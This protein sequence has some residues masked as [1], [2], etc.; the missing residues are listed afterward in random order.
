MI[1]LIVSDLDGTLVP[2]NTTDISEEFIETVKELTKKGILFA[3]ASGRQYYNLKNLF[4]EVQ[5]DIAYVCENGA[6]TVYQNEIIDRVELPQET[7]NQIIRR[8]EKE[9][10][11][12]ILVSG[13][14]T[15]YICPKEKSYEDYIRN[16]KNKYK[17]VEDL[18]AIEEPVIKLAMFEKEGTECRNRQDYWQSQFQA[19]IKVVTS[20][21]LWLDFIF[22]NANKGVGVRALAGH[23][24]IKQEEILAFGDNYNDLEMF[25]ASGTRVA[26]ENAR[27]GISRYCDET[28]PSVNAYLRNLLNN[29]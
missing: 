17:V 25:E 24:G 4:Q 10:G 22:P 14:D 5:D 28:T 23:L 8:L 29:M 19:P 7:A 3:I 15:H 11:T 1:R 20:G 21:P 2:N 26:V 9:P 6:L 13:T 27:P 12:E 18:T 16:M